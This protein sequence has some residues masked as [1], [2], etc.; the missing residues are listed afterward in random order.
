M[1]L[2]CSKAWATMGAWTKNLPKN[3]GTRL[4]PGHHLQLIARNLVFKI[5]RGEPP[6]PLIKRKASITDTCVS[7]IASDTGIANISASPDK[8]NVLP[9]LSR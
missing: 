8:V 7:A 3:V 2:F 1:G 4:S 6:A 5:F 9:Y